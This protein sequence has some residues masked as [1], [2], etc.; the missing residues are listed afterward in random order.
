[1]PRDRFSRDTYVK[2]I[3]EA[4]HRVRPSLYLSPR[5]DIFN[6]GAKVSGSA[7]RIIRERAY[8]HGTMLLD[9]DLS[10]LRN[11]LKSPLSGDMCGGGAAISSVVSPVCK[12]GSIPGLPTIDHEK[13]TLLVME[14][15]LRSHSAAR[16]EVLD[17]TEADLKVNSEIRA[18]ASELESVKWTFDKTPSFNL[19]LS[20]ISIFVE[21]GK[22]TKSSNDELIGQP[23]TVELCNSL[24]SPPNHL[25]TL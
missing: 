25:Q 16:T 13:F 23:F 9:T 20:S 5:H 14:Q 18:I 19:K 2:M 7:Y 24:L 10:L 11:F 22:I 8:H 6:N 15:F 12:I 21:D 1:M 3:V 17:L 4:L